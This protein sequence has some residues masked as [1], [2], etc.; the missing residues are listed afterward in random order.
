MGVDSSPHDDSDRNENLESLRE[1]LNSESVAFVDSLNEQI[2][3]LLENI[4]NLQYE[5]VLGDVSD[6]GV[7]GN[8]H[9]HFDLV[10]NGSKIHCVIF[11]YQLNRLDIDI[12][13]GT[14]MAVNGDL[15]YYDANGSVSLIV[16]QCVPV[17]EG[18]YEQIYRENRAILED[19]GL[20]D[21]A[22]K[23]P[24]PELPQCVGVVTSA[25]SDARKDVV[26]SL[27]GR[28][29]DI[30]IIVQHSTVQGEDAMLS[31]MSAIGRLDDTAHVDVIILT[32]G[33]GSEKDLRVFNETPLCRV[34]FDT[35]TPV[36]VGVGHENDRT[37][38]DEVAD[39]RVMTP[40]HA[41][42]IVPEKDALE[43]EIEAKGERL[44]SAYARVTSDRLEALETELDS[45]Y[46]LRVESRLG[47]FQRDLEHAYEA[48]VTQRLS[49]YDNRLDSALEKFEQQKAHEQAQADAQREFER[50]T[51]RQR[52]AIAV[53]VLLLLGLLGYIFLL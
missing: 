37:L 2:S 3:E 19:D 23:Q 44:E 51:R 46:A 5:Y 50:D 12:E 45:T 14:Q 18:E 20:L 17:G 30:D 16:S 29:P 31:M 11:Q 13:D 27:H 7:S 10:H 36:V 47:A 24:L 48:T 6:Y 33:G 41:G 32:R 4:P 49:A 15:S 1:T 34:I 21:E 35:D 26:T 9:A 28:Y 39:R 43:S 40:T 42:E 52:I 22:G 53:L 8:G 38:A 25:D